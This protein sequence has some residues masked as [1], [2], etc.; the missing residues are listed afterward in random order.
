MTGAEGCGGPRHGVARVV[1]VCLAAFSGIVMMGVIDLLTLPGW[2]DQR[3][4]WEVPLEASWGALFT[5]FLGAAYVWVALFP[6]DPWPAL[7]Q[8]AVGGL[9][10]L[11][12]AAAGTDWRPLAVAL[13]V[14]LS[15]LG[16]WLLLGRPAP[17]P[18]R[19]ASVDAPVLGLALL[20]LLLWSPY[21]LEALARS[22]EGV[23]GS[24]TQGI[25]HWPVQGATG[26][27]ILL[28][29]SWT[30]L[31]VEGRGLLRVAISLAAVYI[32]MAELA[33]PDRAGAMQDLRW[34]IGVTLW[35]VAVAL[36]AAP[37]RTGATR[38]P[39]PVQLA[40][41]TAGSSPR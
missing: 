2:V 6:R 10:L 31:R 40:R 29:A 14:G 36:V 3:Y 34:G 28:A 27:A 9:A 8:L 35:G 12:S 24:V 32:G 17:V 26:I 7:L 20:G 11:V 21:V 4:E 18:G 1:A 41:L 30:A 23:L 16:L 37:T 25:E 13:G 38:R 39:G 33:F 15:G 5:F 19:G 22:R